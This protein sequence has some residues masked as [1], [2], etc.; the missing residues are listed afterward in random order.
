MNK[1]AAMSRQRQDEITN[2]VAETLSE[3]LTPEEKTEFTQKVV[4]LS[5]DVLATTLRRASIAEVNTSKPF[6]TSN[7]ID[8]KDFMI[9]IG[10]KIMTDYQRPYRS[11][12]ATNSVIRKFL[13]LFEYFY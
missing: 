8:V 3:F 6:D 2:K 13:N 10:S 1:V 5:S 4:E 12:R 11:T 9:T 7:Y